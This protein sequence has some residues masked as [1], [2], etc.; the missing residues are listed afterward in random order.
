MKFILR[1]LDEL[2]ICEV[3]ECADDVYTFNVFFNGSKT[4]IEKSFILKKLKG[5]RA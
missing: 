3:T 1:I 4:D 5:Q 2:R